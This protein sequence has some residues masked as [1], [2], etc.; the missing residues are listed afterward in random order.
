MT[1]DV[2]VFQSRADRWR[3][4][5]AFGAVVVGFAVLFWGVRTYFPFLL[6]G[7]ALREF[8]RGYGAAG[9]LVFIAIQALQVVLAPIP[10]QVT[11][12][13]SGYLFGALWGTVYSLIGL[14]I[15]SYV[16]FWL[17]RR[18]GRPFVERVI[19]ADV[20]A[21]FD[22]FVAGAGLPALFVIFLVPGPPD[23][24]ICFLA[25]L[26]DIELRKLVLVAIV[27]RTPAYLLVN[28]FGASLAAEAYLPA[29]ILGL[30]LVG[31]A[32]WGYLNRERLLAA[33]QSGRG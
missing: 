3:F 9:P 1:T 30:V 22:G 27:G 5:L 14:T 17:S 26:T 20:M 21:R 32:L 25:G 4:L 2:H 19:H 12:V 8:I 6:N 18:W 23:D 15:G 10:G 16:A 33:L 13:A 24:A 11:G 29:A 31:A 7:P 28:V